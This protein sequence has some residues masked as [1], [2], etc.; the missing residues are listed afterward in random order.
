MLGLLSRMLAFFWRRA[1]GDEGGDV[2]RAVAGRGSRRAEGAWG[3][4]GAGL[5]RAGR[6]SGS[7]GGFVAS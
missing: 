6:Q 2:R 7:R 5:L 1:E 3:R 4:V